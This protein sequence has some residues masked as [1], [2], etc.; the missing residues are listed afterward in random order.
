MHEQIA[1]NKT[2]VPLNKWMHYCFTWSRASRVKTFYLNGEVFA[3]GTSPDK[4][5]TA[6]GPL[7]IGNYGGIAI[8]RRFLFGGKK[9]FNNLY[10]V[11]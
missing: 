6:T 2:T 8:V 4:D 3:N 5:F 11:H 9:C 7:Y 10:N 1:P